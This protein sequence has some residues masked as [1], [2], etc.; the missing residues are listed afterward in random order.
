MPFNRKA[1]PP[2]TAPRGVR[3]GVRESGWPMMNLVTGERV[4]TYADC[5]VH[6]TAKVL[7]PRYGKCADCGHTWKWTESD[8]EARAQK[9]IRKAGPLPDA[10]CACCSRS[11]KKKPAWKLHICMLCGVYLCDRH[12]HWTQ[13]GGEE[14][15][16]YTDYKARERDREVLEAKIRIGQAPAH[17][18]VVT[19]VE[20]APGVYHVTID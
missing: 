7:D 19:S 8:E 12:V 14:P 4:T 15:L 5:S 3:P 2:K 20:T 13:D 11:A 17:V 6:P 16:C 9:R 10:R 1:E 18:H